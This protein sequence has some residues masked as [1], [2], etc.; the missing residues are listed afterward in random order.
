MKISLEGKVVLI[1]G[2]G[3]GIGRACALAVAEAGAKTALV[4][5]KS[6]W[7]EETA[8]LI[9]DDRRTMT[10]IADVG[11]TADVERA[12]DTIISSFGRLDGAHNNAGIVGEVGPFL[13]YP[14][15]ELR[16]LFEIN[17]L[18][19]WRCMQAEIRQMLKQGGGAIVNTAST[20]SVRA[21]PTVSGYTASK[22]AVLALTRSAAIEYG[23]QGVRVNAVSP[24]TVETRMFHHSLGEE[25]IKQN[26]AAHPIGRIGKPEDISAMVV[27]LL[28]DRSSFMLGSNVFI[29]GGYAQH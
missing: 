4:D 13:D 12:V 26:I 10:I 5:V 8:H 24:G 23:G 20:A 28:S 29:D 27:F 15:E 25:E 17:V 18:G 2:A 14:E 6:D 1:T 16:R 7:V 11:K 3:S 19:V 22:H 21:F 9:G